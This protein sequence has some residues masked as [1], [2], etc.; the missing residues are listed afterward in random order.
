M[1]KSRIVDNSMQSPQTP[2]VYLA[3]DHVQLSD[4][5]FAIL[6]AVIARADRGDLDSAA[7]FR[8]TLQCKMLAHRLVIDSSVCKEF[9]SGERAPLV[10]HLGAETHE[11]YYNC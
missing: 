5:K 10:V 4:C 8:S 3:L 9:E 11:R 6:A 7:L 1:N 2:D